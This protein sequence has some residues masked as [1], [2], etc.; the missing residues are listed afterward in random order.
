MKRMQLSYDTVVARYDYVRSGFLQSTPKTRQRK[1]SSIA[2][3]VANPGHVGQ[4]MP[5]R[6]DSVHVAAMPA[7]SHSHSRR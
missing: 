5:R 1:Y 3:D 4:R 2:V 7:Q 6:T